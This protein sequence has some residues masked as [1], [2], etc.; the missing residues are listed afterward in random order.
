MKFDRELPVFLLLQPIF[1][2]E[3]DTDLGD[4]VADSSLG[5]TQVEVMVWKVFG[6]TGMG[7]NIASGPVSQHRPYVRGP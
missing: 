6:Y 5:I 4:C 1:V 7:M 2:R 3:I